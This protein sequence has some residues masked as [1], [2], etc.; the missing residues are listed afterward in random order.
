MKEISPLELLQDEIRLLESRQAYEFQL[1]RDQFHVTAES[2][3]PANLIASAVKDVV[4]HPATGNKLIDSGIGLVS[5]ILTKKFLFG[6]SA[7]PVKRI[8][9]TILQIGISSIVFR[10]SNAIKAV[11]GT[12]LQS[13]FKKRKED[14]KLLP[15]RSIKI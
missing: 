7:S 15:D 12:I 8:F 11:G 3:K 14:V 2:L 6:S 10:N 13:I 9:G 4:T 1:L 5:G